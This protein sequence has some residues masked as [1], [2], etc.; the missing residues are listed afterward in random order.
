M[1]DHGFETNKPGHTVI[2][3]HRP[4]GH[5]HLDQKHHKGMR[6]PMAPHLPQQ[7]GG[8]DMGGAPPM[9]FDDGMDMNSGS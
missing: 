8:M 1:A 3:I 7:G 5:G 4:Q 2:Q 6:S 9:A